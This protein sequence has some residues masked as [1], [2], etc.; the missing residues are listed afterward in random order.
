MAG[1][2]TATAGK[3]AGF[4]ISGDSLTATNFEIDAS[5]KRIT[6]GDPSSTDLF[7]ADADEG[8]QLGN[9]TF[10]LAPFS[11]TKAGVLKPISGTIGGFQIGSAILNSSN[12]NLI[13]RSSGQITGSTVLFTGGKVGGF[14][15]TSTH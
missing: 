10:G 6:L 12:N 14:K 3:I 7:V 5:S 1:T 8:I 4:T 15:I 11:V 13:M 2:I 9:N